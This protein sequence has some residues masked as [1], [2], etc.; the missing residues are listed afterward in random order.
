MNPFLERYT[1]WTG[2]DQETILAYETKPVIRIN[3]LK[4]P[5][6]IITRLEEKG[7]ELQ[8][9]PFLQD[10]YWYESPFSLGATEEYLLGYYYLQEAAS[11]LPVIALAQAM[12]VTGKTILDMAA[13]P[14][15]KTT[16]LAAVMNNT[17]TLVA[18]DDNRKRCAALANN[19]E[20]CGVTNTFV[21]V[22]DARYAKDLKIQFD[23]ILLDAPCSGNFVLQKN[24]FDKRELSGL[25]SKQRIQLA[26]LTQGL[27]LLNVNGVLVYSTCSLE[28]EE[29]EDVVKAALSTQNKPDGT[30]ELVS[31]DIHGDEGIEGVGVRLWPHRHGTQGFFVAAIKKVS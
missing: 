24:W 7:V 29:N 3:P 8:K 20:R 2:D 17:G 13:A 28:K 4:A 11:Q 6:N 16:Q 9:V 22:K 1:Q 27:S 12:D 21:Y 14:G 19:L 10:A 31:L 18:L 30:Y 23:G 15:S 26:L 5:K 25:A